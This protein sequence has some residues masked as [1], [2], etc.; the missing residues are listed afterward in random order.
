VKLT[1][2]SQYTIVIRTQSSSSSLEVERKLKIIK[3][4]FNLNF[5]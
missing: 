1:D 3:L 4:F 5:I 2:A